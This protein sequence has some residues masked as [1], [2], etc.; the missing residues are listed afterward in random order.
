M[1]KFIYL[2]FGILLPARG[3]SLLDNASLWLAGAFGGDIRN[4]ILGF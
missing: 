2:K 3:G 4:W 1:T